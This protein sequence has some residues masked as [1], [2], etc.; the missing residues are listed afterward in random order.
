MNEDLNKS[1]AGN[2]PD[3]VVAGRDM[4]GATFSEKTK[5]ISF[6][7]GEFSF[8]LFRPVS[9]N[10]ALQIYFH[11]D[12][13]GRSVWVEGT[14]TKVKIRLDGMQTVGVKVLGSFTH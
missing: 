14:I 5:L 8:S 12:M 4:F 10:H 11:Q 7:P 13:S 9:E 2:T 1:L 3:I 6:S